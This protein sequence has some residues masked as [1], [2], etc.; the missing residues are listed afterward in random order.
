MHDSFRFNPIPTFRKE[1]KI[2]SNVYE[3]NGTSWTVKT[4]PFGDVSYL[5][6]WASENLQKLGGLYMDSVPQ[7]CWQGYCEDIRLAPGRV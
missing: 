5:E 3:A 4:S 7:R 2:G 6:R 1:V